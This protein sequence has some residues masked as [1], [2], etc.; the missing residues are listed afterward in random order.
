MTCFYFILNKVVNYVELRTS[1]NSLVLSTLGPLGP[2][3]FQT[4]TSPEPRLPMSR[5][6]N[7]STW[8]RIE[9]LT[10][11]LFSRDRPLEVIK[12]S[13]PSSLRPLSPPLLLLRGS[14]SSLISHPTARDSHNRKIFTVLP[15]M[16]FRLLIWLL[17]CYL[18]NT[19]WFEFANNYQS[20]HVCDS[21]DSLL[22]RH[23]AT[24][25]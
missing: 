1:M 24:R 18:V 22:S 17:A 11:C 20:D 14:S 25:Q 7:V 5:Q 6:D 8:N 2:R 15:S 23:A 3:P 13:R 12:I 9:E 4:A 21:P 10:T 19:T 16:S